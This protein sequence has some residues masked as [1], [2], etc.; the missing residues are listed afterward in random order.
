[1][2]SSS[3]NTGKTK[4]GVAEGGY[5]LA[6]E[7]T[8]VIKARPNLRMISFVGHSLGGLYARY[9]VAALYREKDSTIGGLKPGAYVSSCSPH[10][11]L[12]RFTLSF[13]PSALHPL[14][15]ILIGQTGV[16][17]FLRDKNPLLATMSTDPVFLSPLSSFERR[18]AYANLS[19]DFLVPFATASFTVRPPVR[20]LS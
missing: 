20:H 12:R 19:G 9:A 3:A 18:R 15:G 11:G 4:D 5:R 17:L 16:D 2:H 1:M 7:V 6:A 8:E 10:I 14:S 13:A